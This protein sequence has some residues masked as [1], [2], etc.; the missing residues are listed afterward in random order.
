MF[1]Y[2][3]RTCPCRSIRGHCA[4]L[5]QILDI[6]PEHVHVLGSCGQLLK[7]FVL[8]LALCLVGAAN[9]LL[10]KIL[11]DTY[12]QVA[13]FVVPHKATGSPRQA[14]KP[15]KQHTTQ[16]ANHQNAQLAKAKAK[17]E[18]RKAEMLRH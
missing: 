12:T 5:G 11:A 3:F 8:T 7:F 14:V 9:D 2:V 17:C 4:Q 1:P 16:R 6:W 13:V 10:A 15:S 18:K